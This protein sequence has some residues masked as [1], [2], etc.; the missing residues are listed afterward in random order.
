MGSN[1]TKAQI[2]QLKLSI[3]KRENIIVVSDALVSPQGCS[4]CTWTIWSQMILWQGIG[5]VPGPRLN[6]MYLGLAEAYD[7]YTAL[8]FLQWYIA[9]FPLVLPNKLTVQ[10][11]CNNK[12]LIDQ[13]NHQTHQKY[14]RDTIQDNYPLIGEIQ[15]TI[16]TLQPIS[17]VKGHQDK[18]KLDWL[19]TIPETLNIDCERASEAM[20][21]LPNTIPTNHPMTTIGYPHL[22]S[23][24]KWRIPNVPPI[25]WMAFQ[26]ASQ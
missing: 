1:Y 22:L 20:L 8:S 12:G 21:T 23:S 26:Q 17:H 2:G 13:L 24:N 11:Y 7:M 10:V 4:S 3:S 6:N 15:K 14:P 9:T 16:Q 19:L 25:Q 5:Y 18:V